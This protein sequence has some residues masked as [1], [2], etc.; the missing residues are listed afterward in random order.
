MDANPNRSPITWIHDFRQ[1]LQEVRV[2]FDKI[3]WP[4]QKEY[5]GG[6]VGVLVIVAL[7]TVILGTLDGLLA[8]GFDWLIQA[9]P[10]WLN[11]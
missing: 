5:V 1:Y 10:R 4:S 6:T 11:G 8:V 2:E 7:M 3:S 9:L